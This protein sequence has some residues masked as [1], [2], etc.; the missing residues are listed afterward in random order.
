MKDFTLHPEALELKKLGFNE[1]CFGYF[2][3]SKKLNYDF[4]G[5]YPFDNCP[6]NLR[7]PTYAQAFRFFR[8]KYGLFVEIKCCN[9][10]IINGTFEIEISRLN[11]KM[12]GHYG[13]ETYEEAELECLKKLIEIVKNK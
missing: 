8:E 7:A 9:T 10:K 5:T 1:P 11:D 2:N 4:C 6:V 3:K 12:Y 13:Y